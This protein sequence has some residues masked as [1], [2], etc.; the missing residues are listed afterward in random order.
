MSTFA[1][2]QVKTKNGFTRNIII[3]SSQMAEVGLKMGW[4]SPDTQYAKK[5][6]S[7]WSSKNRRTFIKTS[8]KDST[9]EKIKLKMSASMWVSLGIANGWIREGLNK[10]AG[11]WSGVGEVAGA[12]WNAAKGAGNLIAD[13]AKAVGNAIT[14]A[15]QFYVDTAGKV[16]DTAGKA[17]NATVNAAGQVVD[18]YGRAIGTAVNVAGQAAG[19]VGNAAVGAGQYVGGLANEAKTGWDKSRASGP[20]N[21][22]TGLAEAA[23]PAINAAGKAIDATGRVIANAASETQRGWNT[24]QGNS[25]VQQVAGMA[26][27]MSTSDRQALVKQLQSM[28]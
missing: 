12:G 18:A 5:I 16:M 7:A 11:F 26:R 4:I 3:T 28:R 20:I 27:G 24:S 14:G 13:G 9:G 23:R 21:P 15:A 19:A 8:S 10:T 6:A 25:N 2:I 17:V 1:T 22:M